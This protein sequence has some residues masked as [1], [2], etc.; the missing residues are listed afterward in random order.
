MVTGD[1]RLQTVRVSDRLASD[2]EIVSDG[3]SDRKASGSQRV[4]F[5][6]SV[7]DGQRV[8]FRWSES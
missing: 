6:Q 4:S 1:R 3:V 7:S 5:R 8:S 2:G